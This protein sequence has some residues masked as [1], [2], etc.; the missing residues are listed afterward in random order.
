M[1]ADPPLAHGAVLNGL[2]RAAAERRLP[3]ALLFEGP[4]GVGKFLSARRLVLGLL[5]AG[6]PGD[7]CGSCG[8]CKR[9][10]SG[11]WRGNHPDVHVLDPLA[12]ET[13][14]IR[15]SR[16]AERDGGEES[17]EAF[18]G[19]RAMEGGWR[20]VL[21]REA[22][23]MNPA[24]QNALLKTLEEP[25]ADTLLVLETH[26]VELLLETIR[27]RCVRV[28]FGRLARGDAARLTAAGG[29][30][31]AE[32]ARLARWCRGSPGDALALAARAGVELRGLLGDVLHGRAEPIETARAVFA[33][34]GE[35]TGSTPLAKERDRARTMLELALAVAGDGRRVL[36]GADPG[37]LAH[38][39]LFR[40]GVPGHL[41]RAALDALLEARVDVERNL[42]PAAV[43][44]R[45]LL[46]LAAGAQVPSS[47]P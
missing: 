43:V 7:P 34:E 37:D 15:V 10:L 4:S 28:R 44:E 12:E 24:A 42:G 40:D 16:I 32:A 20:V 27:S 39:E 26:R 23:R 31:E 47:R 38:G 41:D 29:V 25:G 11:D 22:H 5:C 21:I 2:W 13:E 14:I 33:L 45:S 36:A 35:F 18:L 46:V 9:L 1:R 3:H 6:G 8:P 30:E 17:A 19:L